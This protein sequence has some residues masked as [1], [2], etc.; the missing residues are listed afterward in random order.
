M[1]EIIYHNR[2]IARNVVGT[3]VVGDTYRGLFIWEVDY[4]HKV[5]YLTD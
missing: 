1:Y 5:V 2:I 4:R 3:F